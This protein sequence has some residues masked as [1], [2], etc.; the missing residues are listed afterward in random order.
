MAVHLVTGYAGHGHVTSAD[1]GLFNAGVCG[2]DRYILQTG[3]KFA[4]TIES[5]N[6]IRIGSGGLVDQGRYINIPTNTSIDVA[7]ENGSQGKR[8]Y[9]LIVMRYNKDQSTSIESAEIVVIKGTETSGTPVQ[10]ACITGDIYAGALQDDVPLYRVALD[11]LSI[12]GVTKLFTEISPLAD[13]SSVLENF[14][15]QI[16]LA[17]YPV[18]S[19]YISA[20]ATSPATL[21]GGSWTRIEDSFLLAA[22]SSYEAGS[23]GGEAAHVLT[24]A[25]IPAHTHTGPSHQHTVLAHTHTIPAHAH[26]VPAHTHSASTSSAGAHSH[27]LHRWMAGGSGTVRYAAQGDNSTPTYSTSSAG[28]H[29][30]TV[31]VGS[32]AAFNT[33][34]GGGGNTGA[35]TAANTTASGTGNTGSTGG[36]G[37]HNN[38]PP[39][40]AVYIWQRTA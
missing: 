5:S 31:T 12:T 6:L 40:L 28:A 26:T 16:L 4:Y 19:I 25:E 32:K 39:Y 38:M 21:F 2:L 17:A 36:G 20:S 9:D 23:T 10:P 24:N 13:I 14:R 34:S 29:T 1:E 15:S 11:G 18:G 8:R 3:T 27:T 30:H 7:I 37:A 22:G 33:Q 35:S